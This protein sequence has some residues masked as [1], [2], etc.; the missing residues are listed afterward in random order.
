MGDMS[1]TICDREQIPIM[2]DVADRDD[3]SG[4]FI[5]ASRSGLQKSASQMYAKDRRAARGVGSVFAA[6]AAEEDNMIRGANY[7]PGGVRDDKSKQGPMGGY[8]YSAKDRDRGKMG[9]HAGWYG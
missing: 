7:R 9:G 8:G 4:A 5:K 3:E 2:Y 6:A 1:E